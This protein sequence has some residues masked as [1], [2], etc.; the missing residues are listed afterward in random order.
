MH[1]D[2]SLSFLRECKCR[3]DYREV[4]QK[5]IGW[6]NIRHAKTRKRTANKAR[7]NGSYEEYGAWHVCQR[8]SNIICLP[9]LRYH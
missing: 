6:V 9:P 7:V 4:E 2:A 3:K 8:S 5:F 1:Q